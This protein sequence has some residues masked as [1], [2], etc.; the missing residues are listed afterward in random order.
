MNPNRRRFVVPRGSGRAKSL[1]TDDP[2]AR[3]EGAPQV[4]QDVSTTREAEA[5]RVVQTAV[6]R[7]K[8]GK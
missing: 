7:Q 2:R 6:T 3:R 4:E 5:P 8:G 1:G